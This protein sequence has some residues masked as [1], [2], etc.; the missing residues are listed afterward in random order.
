MDDEAP[1]TGAV[2][3]LAK[4]GPS[5]GSPAE[6]DAPPPPQPEKERT[7]KPSIQRKSFGNDGG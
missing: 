1:V 5:A 3:Q 2:G 4:T 7:K 6:G